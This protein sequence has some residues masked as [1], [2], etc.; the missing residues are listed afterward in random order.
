MTMKDASEYDALDEY[1]NRGRR[2]EEKDL[3]KN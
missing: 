2:A 3:A 1:Y